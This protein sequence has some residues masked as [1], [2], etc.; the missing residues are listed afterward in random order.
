MYTDEIFHLELDQRVPTTPV[1]GTFQDMFSQDGEASSPE[2]LFPSKSSNR[3]AEL[4]SD[5]AA[6][7]QSCVHTPLPHVQLN[8]FSGHT[9]NGHDLSGGENS[10]GTATNPDTDRQL[11][12]IHSLWSD[13]GSPLLQ[14]ALVTF[15]LRHRPE[16]HSF[17]SVQSVGSLDSVAWSDDEDQTEYRDDVMK[18][19]TSDRGWSSHAS[20]AR[21]HQNNEPTLARGVPHGVSL[22]QPPSYTQHIQAQT[23]SPAPESSDVATDSLLDDIMEC[24]QDGG[25][26][27]GQSKIA[28]LTTSLDNYIL[29]GLH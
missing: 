18:L 5:N 12:K 25:F 29:I 28:S 11:R 8:P 24:I 10:T 4:P 23:S 22:R 27:Q 15:D 13:N 20:L 9:Y 1:R 14:S 21:P 16:S 6:R 26:S 17:D 3:P 7:F 19:D 2:F